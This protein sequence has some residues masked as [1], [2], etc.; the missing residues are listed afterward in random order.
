MTASEVRIT[1]LSRTT[2][3]PP[4]TALPDHDRFRLECQ[5][6]R[7]DRLIGLVLCAPNRIGCTTVTL[8]SV[9]PDKSFN[10]ARQC[11]LCYN[12]LLPGHCSNACRKPS[13]CSV[14]GCGRKHTK[15]RHVYHDDVDQVTNAE[16]HSNDNDGNQLG[17]ADVGVL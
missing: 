1:L 9:R 2:F 10:V 13:V 8:S 12:C 6:T 11:K 15:F 4:R 17:V 16:N 14:P 3:L 5:N 7:K